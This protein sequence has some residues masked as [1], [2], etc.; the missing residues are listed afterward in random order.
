MFSV[1][2]FS[3]YFLQQAFQN[4]I[5]CPYCLEKAEEDNSE[6]WV[7]HSNGGDLHPIHRKCAAIWAKAHEICMSCRAPLDTSYI[8]PGRV[9]SIWEKI[10]GCLSNSGEWIAQVAGWGSS[11]YIAL[12]APM[13]LERMGGFSAA[14]IAEVALV[15][16]LNH[17][18]SAFY[19]E[20]RSLQKDIDDFM[21]VASRPV[22][23]LNTLLVGISGALIILNKP[24]KFEIKASEFPLIAETLQGCFS[25]ALAESGRRFV[26]FFTER[27]VQR[28]AHSIFLSVS[29]YG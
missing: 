4:E 11:L 22:L 3:S 14:M 28:I 6:E 29:Q 15:T 17:H 12:E 21:F 24:E 25:F 16:I 1:Q 8:L 23:A 27:T 5:T 9:T 20:Q 18:N 2:S 10:G 7:A 13:I 26:T 19:N